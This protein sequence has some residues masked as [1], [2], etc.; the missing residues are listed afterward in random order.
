M[1]EVPMQA[2][3]Q[4]A[5][6]YGACAEQ[7]LPL[8]T[9]YICWQ[10]ARHVQLQKVLDMLSSAFGRPSLTA[11]FTAVITKLG[12]TSSATTLSELLKVRC[13]IAGSFWTTLVC[14]IKSHADL[15]RLEH[16]SLIGK[17]CS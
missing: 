3:G 13:V 4:A 14:C 10:L 6:E 2:I 8:N 15:C 16:K 5:E 17:L 1:L 12:K 7:P 9:A 11:S